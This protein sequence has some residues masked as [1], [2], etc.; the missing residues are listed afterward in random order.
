MADIVAF[1]PPL[2]PFEFWKALPDGTLLSVMLL[3]CG[4]ITYALGL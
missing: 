1:E 4:M 2:P 3:L